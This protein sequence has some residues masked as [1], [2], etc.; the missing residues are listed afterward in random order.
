[1][2]ALAELNGKDGLYVTRA[3]KKEQREAEVRK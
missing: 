2:R 1:M 3:L